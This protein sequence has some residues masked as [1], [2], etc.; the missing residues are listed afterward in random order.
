[1]SFS[2]CKI[3]TGHLSFSINNTDDRCLI[4]SSVMPVSAFMF[5]RMPSKPVS[6]YCLLKS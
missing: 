1:M 2:P 5:W 6:S 4:A 3:N